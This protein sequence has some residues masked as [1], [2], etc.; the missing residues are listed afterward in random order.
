MVPAI[1]AGCLL[2]IDDTSAVNKT[3]VGGTGLWSAGGNWNPFGQPAPGDVVILQQ[4]AFICTLD[5]SATIPSLQ[6]IGIGNGMTLTQ[7][8]GVFNSDTSVNMGVTP[9]TATYNHNG[10]MMTH[11]G[12]NAG[13][14]N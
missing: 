6:S 5:A 14:V 8:A 10:G 11:V 13:F 7:T 9:G 12:L 4:G 2:A 3:W 1:L